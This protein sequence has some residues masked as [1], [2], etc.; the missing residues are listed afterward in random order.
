V[1]EPTLADTGF[2]DRREGIISA[3]HATLLAATLDV[4]PVVLSDGVLP[5]PWHWAC[6]LPDAPTN[7][8]GADGHP[9]RRPE[10]AEF[11]N[12]MWVGGRVEEV[13][14]LQLGVTAQRR[15]ELV[16]AQRKDGS[17][18]SFWLLQVAH[19]IEQADHVCIEERQDIVL[20][21]AS[22]TPTPADDATAPEAEWVEARTATPPLLFRYSALTFNS[23]R[24][25]YDHP[26]ATT[27]EGYPDL[28]VHGPLT[29]TL[30]CGFA[31]SQ[32]GQ[33]VTAFDFRARAPLFANR[34][35]WLAANAVEGGASVQ[36]IRNDGTI[37]MTCDVTI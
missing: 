1:S 25:H 6:F 10:M 12:R 18:G 31:Q 26:Y 8:L 30:C 32:R 23:H 27:V 24:I 35:F 20:R 19:T 7:T 11:P 28:V 16:D 9:A 34:R 3:D 29:A 4:D 37:A 36:A 15:S 17:S 22:A 13:A 5:I 21:T 2:T 33:A 14:P